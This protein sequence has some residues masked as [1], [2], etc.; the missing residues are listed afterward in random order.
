ME[1]QTIIFYGKS[2]AGKGTQSGLLKK[3][4]EEQ[5]TIHSV[6]CVETG[7]RFR[8]FANSD[9]MTAKLVKQTLDSGLLLPEF[10]PIWVWTT[11]LVENMKE[12][13]HLIFD[14]VA[15]RT[16]EVPILEQAL[17]F[18]KRPSVHVMVIKISDDCAVQRLL[19]RGRS[20]DEEQKIRKRLSWFD[21]NVGQSIQ[22]W[23]DIE[24]IVVHDID[25]E[26]T[27]AD[28]HEEILKT[29]GLNP[30][31]SNLG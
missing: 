31:R 14:G 13:Q 4:F 12:G 8:E 24:N 5:D 16:K 9:S 17:G 22:E 20:D 28:I 10:L 15:R 19:G 6:L 26:H 7:A 1:L 25:G 21:K 30:P 18:Y 23:R 29:L 27:I 2:G 11:F 3:F